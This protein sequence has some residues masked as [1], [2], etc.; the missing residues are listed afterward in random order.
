MPFSQGWE[1]SR[2]PIILA[3]SFLIFHLIFLLS[4]DLLIRN[5]AQHTDKKKIKF[6]SYIRKFKWDRV[7]SQIWGWASWYM[8]KFAN[9][10]P[11]MRMPWVVYD[12]APDPSEFPDLWGI[13][14]YQ[15]KGSNEDDVILVRTRYLKYFTNF[16]RSILSSLFSGSLIKCY[17][18]FLVWL[19]CRKSGSAQ[20]LL[21][22]HQ[23]F[24]VYFNFVFVLL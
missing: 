13:F 21:H 23:Y 8:R 19:R 14:F 4:L 3:H 18:L 1:T 10:S 22:L 9:F 15:F 5:S 6:S 12:F 17:K 11:Y 20:C 16:F 7:Q 24:C 2:N